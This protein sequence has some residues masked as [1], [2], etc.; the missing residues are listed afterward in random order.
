MDIIGKKEVSGLARPDRLRKANLKRNQYTVSLLREGL[1]AGML[2]SQE[3]YHIQ[4]ALMRILQDMICRYTQ[5]ESTSVTSETAESIMASIMYAV[6]AY[7]LHFADPDQAVMALKTEDAGKIHRKGVELIRRCLEETKRLYLEVKK[8]RLDVPVDAYNMTID[9]SLPVFLKKYGIIFDAHNTMASIDY[10]LAIDDIR[11]QGV[12]YIRQYLRN[13]QI[14]TEFCHFFNRQDLLDLLSNY[15]KVCRF[16]YRIELFNIFE[17]MLNNAVFSVLAGGDANRAAISA[18]QYNL[19]N[20]MLTRLSASEIASAMNNA[21]D[22]LQYSLQTAPSLTDYMNRC[23]D[24]LIRRVITAANNRSLQTIIIRGKAEKAKSIVLLNSEHGQMSDLRLRQLVE[25]IEQ[26][27]KKEE[28]VR[29]IRDNFSCLHDFLDLLDS[30][31]LNGAEYDGLFAT[32]GD[33]ELAIFTKIVFY[34][35]LRSD[36]P[37]FQ[38][39]I[40]SKKEMEPDW[41]R[42]FVQFMQGLGGTRLK[43]IENLVPEIDYEEIGFC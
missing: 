28:K 9:E 31:C 35:E 5:G 14:E 4:A 27:E 12:F 10:P 34:E 6:D 1:R 32:F 42:Y 33:L 26:C 36:L 13:L 7:T 41:R 2:T 18:A 25:E 40:F 37:D 39:I 19:L 38:S 11:L 17:L 3:V 30:D 29:L 22:R 24:N 8:N 21:M 23:R 20:R 43:S 15:G 16:N